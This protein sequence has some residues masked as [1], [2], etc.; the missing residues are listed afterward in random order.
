MH[1]EQSIGFWIK[2]GFLAG[3]LPQNLVYCDY[4]ASNICNECDRRGF[5]CR[6][7]EE[8]SV[9]KPKE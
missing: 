8:L 7:V 5:Y 3:I 1:F 9:R 2:S 4:D 6:E